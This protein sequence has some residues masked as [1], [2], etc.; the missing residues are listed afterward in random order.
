M[1]A[2]G[3]EMTNICAYQILVSRI[4]I[5]FLGNFTKYETEKKIAFDFTYV[6][7]GKT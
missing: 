7:P 1:T 6:L 4:M 2:T 5:L 3:K